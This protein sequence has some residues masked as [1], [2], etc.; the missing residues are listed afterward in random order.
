MLDETN[1]NK[2]RSIIRLTIMIR[3]TLLINIDLA[4]PIKYRP[5]GIKARRTETTPSPF[6]SE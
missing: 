3:I 2:V 4:D 6:L 5:A 1:L